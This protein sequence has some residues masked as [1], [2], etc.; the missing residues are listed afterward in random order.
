MR[1]VTLRKCRRQAYR[2]LA[3]SIRGGVRG[4]ADAGRGRA[5][6]HI[7]R[8]RWRRH[9][10]PW[11]PNREVG[12]KGAEIADIAENTLGESYLGVTINAGHE[13][14]FTNVSSD[15]LRALGAMRLG[16]D[17]ALAAQ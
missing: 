12:A 3:L 15:C 6:A 17:I 16:L 11:L 1:K 4:R 2:H 14:P 8:Q 10:A 13:K 9:A 7:L 5:R